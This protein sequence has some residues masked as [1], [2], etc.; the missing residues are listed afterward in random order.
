M[1]KVIM[2][3][4]D[5]DNVYG[6]GNWLVGMAQA[7]NPHFGE[8]EPGKSGC[9]VQELVKLKDAGFTAG[10]IVEMKEGGLL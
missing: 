4:D 8:A 7:N 2:E 1:K 6:P 3:I 9:T 5:N 10:E